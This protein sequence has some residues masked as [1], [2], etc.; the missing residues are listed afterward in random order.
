MAKKIIATS[1][2]HSVGATFMDWSI[3]FLSGQ[4][5]YYYQPT[6]QFINVT[7]NPLE[8]LYNQRGPAEELKNAHGHKKNHPY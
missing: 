7:T 1:S 8:N 2:I 5:E 4:K 6:R 3:L